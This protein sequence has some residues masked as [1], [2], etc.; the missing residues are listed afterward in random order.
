[1]AAH[2]YKWLLAP[3]GI[4]VAYVNRRVREWLPPAVISWRSHRDWRQVD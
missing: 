2:G 1:M 4:G 3:A